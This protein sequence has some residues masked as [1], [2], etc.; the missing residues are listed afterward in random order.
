[1]K[2]KMMLLTIAALLAFPL[3]GAEYTSRGFC[4]VISRSGILR[5][6]TC[7]GKEILLDS[8]IHGNYRLPPGE[9]KYDTRLI[10]AQDGAGTAKAV[11]EGDTM[12][13]TTDSVLGNSKIPKA[14][15]YHA[16]VILKPEEITFRTRITLLTPLRG[17]TSLFSRNFNIPVSLVAG[18]GVRWIE[19]NGR[20]ILRTVPREFQT[21]FR[22][23][24]KEATF[25]LPGS[26]L[27]ISASDNCV[28]GFWDSRQWKAPLLSFSMSARDRWN[29]EAVTY[30][31]GKSWEWE[32]RIRMT[33]D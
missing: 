33:G 31:A 2:K 6:V 1:M 4:A 7:N 22:I 8:Q 12:T 24:G 25:S 19:D 3:I 20:E 30:P 11:S 32:F 28:I 16:V 27:T 29:A 13:V 14:A 23:R 15:S 21:D 9:A 17:H 18:R 5:K 26:L 10:Q